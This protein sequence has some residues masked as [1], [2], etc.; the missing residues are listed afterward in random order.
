[1]IRSMTGFGRSSAANGRL[2]VTVELR[3]VNHRFA[4]LRMRLPDGLSALEPDLRKRVL[5]RIRRGRV[6]LDVRLD[7]SASAAMPAS[8]NR[9]LVE[10]ILAAARTLHEDY[11]IE[12]RM[13]LGSVLSAPGVLEWS[14]D[15]N[16][17]DD[18]GRRFVL[19]TVEAAL[20]AIDVERAREG[21]ALREDL[22]DRLDRMRA[23]VG[24]ISALAPRIPATLERRLVERLKA[25]SASIDLDPARVAQEAAFLAERSDVTEELVRLGAHVEQARALLADGDGEPVGKRLDFL[26]QEIH[27]ETNTVT[28]KSQDLELSRRALD[29]KAETEKVRE[30]IQNLE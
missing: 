17:L 6:E 10:G 4:D 11:G 28:S 20:D 24:E 1:M 13:D 30:Q 18:D 25:L 9:P 16:A 23:I 19:E 8:L 26:L 15:R 12:G 2:R 21:D 14:P 29:L 5:D 7:R 22:S 27:R 3:S